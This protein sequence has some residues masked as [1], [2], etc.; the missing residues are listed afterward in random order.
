MLLVWCE[1]YLFGRV[2]CLHGWS[3]VRRAAM[4][5]HDRSFPLPPKLE[6]LCLPFILNGNKGCYGIYIYGGMLSVNAISDLS[7]N[8]RQSFYYINNPLNKEIYENY[9]IFRKWILKKLFS[10]WKLMNKSASIWRLKCSVFCVVWFVIE[11]IW[12]K[13]WKCNI[14][15]SSWVSRTQVVFGK[16]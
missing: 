13:V 12:V 3:I 5:G 9:R 4:V 15:L 8:P 16:L 14:Y 2:F 6:A 1:F 10:I 11:S 7:S